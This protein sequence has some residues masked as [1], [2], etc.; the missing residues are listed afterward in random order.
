MEQ[1]LDGGAV[2]CLPTTT[3]PAPLR[4]QPVAE[5]HTLRLRNSQLTSVAGL[6]GLPQLTLPLAEVNGF[7]VGFSLMG[8]KGSDLSLVALAGEF[9]AALGR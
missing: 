2:I 8:R 4:G 5:R 7:P 9:E 6:T 1:V 3:S